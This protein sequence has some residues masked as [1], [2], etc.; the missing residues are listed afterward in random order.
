MQLP[1]L[2]WTSQKYHDYT[3]MGAIILK[4]CAKCIRGSFFSMQEKKKNP[5]TKDRWPEAHPESASP[6]IFFQSHN[7]TLDRQSPVARHLLGKGGRTCLF[8]PETSPVRRHLNMRSH[9]D[10]YAEHHFRMLHSPAVHKEQQLLPVITWESTKT[11]FMQHTSDHK[12]W[13]MLKDRLNKGWPVGRCLFCWYLLVNI[14]QNTREI[15]SLPIIQ[16]AKPITV[17]LSNETKSNLF[18]DSRLLYTRPINGSFG[19]PCLQSLM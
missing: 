10:N 17:N 14:F 13:L 11:M 6:C 2:V 1:L 3:D 12:L 19:S 7:S 9:K 15:R 16:P 4:T 5:L 8:L 18:N